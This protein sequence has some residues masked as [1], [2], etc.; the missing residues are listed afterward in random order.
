MS[1]DNVVRPAQ[2]AEREEER[3]HAEAFDGYRRETEDR[4]ARRVI[5]LLREE[6]LLVA[7]PVP[8]ACNASTSQGDL[9]R[10]PPTPSTAQVNPHVPNQPANEG[11]TP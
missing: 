4:I 5:E 10:V 9:L 11:A 8:C 1:D 3:L 6:G 7:V 2:F